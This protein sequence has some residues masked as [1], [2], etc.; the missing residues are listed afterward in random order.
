MLRNIPPMLSPD[1]VKALMEMGHGDEILLAD[2]NFPGHSI[3][4]RVIRADGI[5]IPELLDAVLTL[6]P[7]D[8]YSSW[9]VGL[10]ETV[11]GDPEPEVWKTY[12]E[13][14][15]KHEE[16]HSVKTFERFDFYRH[17]PEVAAVVLTGET[18]LYGNI[19]LKKGVL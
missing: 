7:L 17:T 2:A 3:H 8:P 4:H 14:I 6:M 18:A 11:P 12:N 13:I 19:I 9:Q 5:G 15:A 10:M 16:Q 1:L